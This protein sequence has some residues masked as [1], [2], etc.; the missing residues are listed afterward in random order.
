MCL[1][2]SEVW[3]HVKS[4]ANKLEPIMAHRIVGVDGIPI[5][6][7][8]S[9]TIQLTIAGV[10]FQH[11]FIVADQITADAILRLDFLE[12]NKCVQNLAKGE[13]SIDEKIVALSSHSSVGTVGCAKVTMMDTVTVPAGSELEIMGHVYSAVQGTWLVESNDTN[14][15]P[16]CV[17][18]ALVSN[19][20]DTVP[21]RVV[22]TSLTPAIL[23]RKSRIAIA[24]LINDS[25][26]GT[27]C[28]CV[29]YRKV[30]NITTKDAYP[31][32]RVDGMLD[33][34]AGSV[35]FSTLDLKSGYWQVEV[36]PKDHE[37]NCILFSG[38]PL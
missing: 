24:E 23:Y 4:E 20:G 27:T 12:A 28:F 6:V 3:E 16:V 18:R 11:K 19:Q 13:L 2:K 33:T 7:Q 29:D 1:L 37:K 14:T 17:A 35:W 8:S 9:A 30:N 31:L 15:L 10:K 36:A 38:R 5:E 25:N 26:I 22:N 21:L 32:P 34:L